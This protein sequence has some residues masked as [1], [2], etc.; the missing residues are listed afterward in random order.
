M[1]A[2]N[3][4]QKP[5]ANADT[6]ATILPVSEV[7]E[8][9]AKAIAPRTK[10]IGVAQKNIADLLHRAGLAEQILQNDC[11]SLRV[12]HEPNIPLS[13]KQEQDKLY[14]AHY[15]TQEDKTFIDVEVVFRVEANGRLKLTQT[16]TQDPIRGGELRSC[17]TE[18]ARLFSQKLLDQ[19]F[20]DAIA[21][22]MQTEVSPEQAVERLPQDQE[23]M[24]TESVE[25]DP[26]VAE[27]I[28]ALISEQSPEDTAVPENKP[29]SQNQE[30]VIAEAAAIESSPSDPLVPEV[31]EAFEPS[32]E[33]APV[34]ATEAN[35]TQG[36]LDDIQSSP[37]T[38]IAKEITELT[39]ETPTVTPA[40]LVGAIAPE[41]TEVV[42]MKSDSPDTP[43]SLTVL[44][45][46]VQSWRKVAQALSKSKEYLTRIE[47]V[48][49]GYFSSQHLSKEAEAALNQDFSQYEKTLENLRRWYRISIR[50]GA[51]KI[52]LERIKAVAE[53]F[54]NGQPLSQN[55]IASMQN[56]IQ[57][58][59][60]S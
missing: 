20:E 9:R 49:T 47:Q 16:V 4:S 24:T 50:K 23:L 31:V 17:S 28:E 13:I 57:S 44:A 29:P 55:A 46:R 35:V 39:Q 7:I 58:T 59:S 53:G 41:K 51:P 32:L 48:S 45:E 54:K 33:I 21:Q 19:G 38:D 11:F 42:Q 25:N 26:P 5:I 60:E 40:V 18:I 10:Q 27:V 8:S 22:S 37:Q 1:P 15:L 34:S 3:T 56:D 36:T 30:P 14:L 6:S 43:P 2:K 12:E 52:Y